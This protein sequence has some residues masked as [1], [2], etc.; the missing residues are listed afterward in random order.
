MRFAGIYF[1]GVSAERRAVVV[2]L[3][4]SDLALSQPDG[5][6]LVV[7]PLAA[8]ERTEDETEDGS[9]RLACGV[10]R[11]RIADAS[12]SA[13]LHAAAPALAPRSAAKRALRGIAIIALTGAVGL[14]L[15]L[16]VPHLDAP[17]AG[18]LPDA[19]EA[20]L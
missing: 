18:L 20:R 9:T 2:S 11:L 8:V 12:F 7:W 4:N 13:A 17:I 19:W 6:P 10:A 3:G 14:A 1:D 15:W 5:S 16:V